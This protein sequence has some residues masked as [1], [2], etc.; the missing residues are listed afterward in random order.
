MSEV[1]EVVGVCYES[2]HRWV[3]WYRPGGLEEV[4]SRRHGESGRKEPRLLEG[5]CEKLVQK[6]KRGELRTISDGVRWA[7][8]EGDPSLVEKSALRPF[9]KKKDSRSGNQLG[10]AFLA[11]LSGASGAAPACREGSW[12]FFYSAPPYKVAYTYIHTQ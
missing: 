11:G 6:A 3:D 2:M 1:A 5:D 10:T 9:H 8:E 7:R 12:G 4:P